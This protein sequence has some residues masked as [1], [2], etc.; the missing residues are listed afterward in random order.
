MIEIKKDVPLRGLSTMMTEGT[1]QYVVEWETV[2]DLETLM[3][4]IRYEVICETGIKPLGHGSNLLFVEQNYKRALLKC[5]AQG[6]RKVADDA[7]TVVLEA[8]AGMA[9][10]D[11]ISYC[12]D[13]NIW[14]IENLSLIPGTVGAAAVQNVGAYGVEFKDVVVAVNCF[15][16]VEKRL[17]R[18]VVNELEYGYRASLFKHAGVRDRYVVVSVVI[19]LS[20]LPCPRLSY[21]N[22]AQ[23]VGCDCDINALRNAVIALR[24]TKLP[25]VGVIG[26]AGSFFKNPI[27]SDDDYQRVAELVACE[28][29]DVNT[30]PAYEVN[31]GHKLS[32]AWL[33][34][35]A[36]WKGVTIGHAAVWPLQPLVLVNADGKASGKDIADLAAAISND[37][38]RKF[39][40]RLMPEVEY[41]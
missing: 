27:V 23:M 19:R 18:F 3:S 36:G 31:N 33:I 17:K 14:G 24:R 4:D 32:A 37:V 20:K 12:C 29:I 13:E 10:D 26:S 28:G 8:D 25:E 5:V 9:L 21:G 2:D 38:E 40:V 1:A 7:E 41:L 6:V 35:R 16:I 34:D 39:G 30:M 11:L 15:D 22:L